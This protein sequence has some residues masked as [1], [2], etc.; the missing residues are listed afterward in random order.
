[1]R[2]ERECGLYLTSILTAVLHGTEIPQLPKKLTWESVYEMSLRHGVESMV[3]WG[4]KEYLDSESLL[5]KEWEGKNSQNMIQALIQEA[6]TENLCDC[7]EQMGIRTIPLKGSVLR[8]LYSQPYFRYMGDM[9]F[10]IEEDAASKAR[11]FMEKL[12]YQ[13]E[14]FGELYHDSYVKRPYLYVELHRKLT[15]ED[16]KYRWYF[17]NIWDRIIPDETHPGRFR[18]SWED[19]YIYHIVH[20][21][22]HYDHLGSGIRAIMDTYLFLQRYGTILDQNKLTEAF[23]KLEL[24]EVRRFM[25]ELSIRWF[26]TKDEKENA[27]ETDLSDIEEKIWG[28]GI[29]GTRFFEAVKQYQNIVE[30]KKT[31]PKIRYLCQRIF[32]KKEWMLADY[33]ILDKVPILLPVCWIHR[34]IK[35]VVTKRELLER[36]F[37]LLIKKDKK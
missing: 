18:L 22:K 16:S 28:S 2:N 14:E 9:D 36:E 10:L 11:S 7:F 24:E 13:V 19:F 26:G 31:F 37:R 6:E 12:G 1:M 15:F 21:I 20:F 34:G 8:G 5:F 35:A 29:F 30:E 4:I 33:P 3:Y 25:E 27:A 23:E 32:M 17:D